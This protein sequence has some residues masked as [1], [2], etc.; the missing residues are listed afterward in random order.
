MK[1][2]EYSEWLTTYMWTPRQQIS[3]DMRWLRSQEDNQM[4]TEEWDC[5]VLDWVI[6]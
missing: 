1:M 4:V 6:G 2:A 5:I 3:D